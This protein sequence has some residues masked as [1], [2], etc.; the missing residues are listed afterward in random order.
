MGDN[1]EFKKLLIAET[2]IRKEFIKENQNILKKVKY[3]SI[4]TAFLFLIGILF[5]SHAL[6]NKILQSKNELS[7]TIRNNKSE[8]LILKKEVEEG[9]LIQLK[10]LQD[11]KD[12]ETRISLQRFYINMNTQINNKILAKNIRD[13]IKIEILKKEIKDKH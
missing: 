2:E 13:S 6:S 10:S 11:I 3:L 8:I 4:I 5:W 12:L 7:K 9:K 1:D